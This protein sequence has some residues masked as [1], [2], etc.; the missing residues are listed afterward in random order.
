MYRVIVAD[1]SAMTRSKLVTLLRQIKEISEIEEVPNGWEAVE[2]FKRK[3]AH[4]V[5]M[6]IVMPIMD[7][8]D[9]LKEIKALDSAAIVIMVSSLNQKDVL[10]KTLEMG[11]DHYILKPFTLEGI[12]TA[13]E[14]SLGVDLSI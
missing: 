8:I 7:G 1:D 3:P 14:N 11:A 13:I 2:L 6:D 9:A 5:T 10:F 12:K 4:I